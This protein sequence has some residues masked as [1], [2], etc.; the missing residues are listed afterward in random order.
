MEDT[1]QSVA[2]RSQIQIKVRGSRFVAE[3]FG[4]GGEEEARG[5]I[6]RVQ[7]KSH[8]ATHHCYAYR[9][10]ID[11]RHLRTNDDGEPSGT[12]GQPILQ[13]ID[14]RS[15]TNTLTI[16]TRYFGGTKLG[17]GGLIRAYGDAASQSLDAAGARTHYLYRRYHIRFGFD[18]TAPAMHLIES[19]GGLMHDTSYSEETRLTVDIRASRAAEFE[20]RFV[21]ML[22]GRGTLEMVEEKR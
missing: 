3:S 9:V 13:Q 15:L 21:E 16:V 5:I 4:V 10:G 19:I 11:G 7:R 8:D 17:R 12:A 18:D 2:G 6:E 22:G 1:Y 20:R 14:A